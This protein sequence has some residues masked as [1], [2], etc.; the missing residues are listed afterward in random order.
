[1]TRITISDE[2]E[3]ELKTIRSGEWRLRGDR[4]LDG[5]VAFLVDEYKSR[6][7]V[8]RQIKELKETI[9]GTMEEAARKGTTKGM[10]ELFSE[11]LTLVRGKTR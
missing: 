8:E 10:E 3:S 6:R 5:V 2:L 9:I 11:M 7:T 1:M 4:G